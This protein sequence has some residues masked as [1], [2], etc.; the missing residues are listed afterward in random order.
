MTAP[1][2]SDVYLA[3]AKRI[4]RG[5]SLYSCAAVFA[6]AK[7]AQYEYSLLHK[8]FDLF[9]SGHVSPHGFLE[10]EG[11]QK[12]REWRLTA[13]CLMAAIAKSEGD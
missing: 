3:A 2:A 6:V 10:L 4:F 11:E 7:G 8:Y 1:R 9:L 5:K 12:Q 13:L